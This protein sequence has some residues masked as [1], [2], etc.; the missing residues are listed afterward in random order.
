MKEKGQRGRRT[1]DPKS[2][3]NAR[4]RRN[5]TSRRA[6]KIRLLSIYQQTEAAIAKLRGAPTEES[7]RKIFESVQPHLTE[8]LA[9]MMASEKDAVAMKA[10]QCAQVFSMAVMESERA[11]LV[12]GAQVAGHVTNERIAKIQ[13]QME[14]KAAGLPVTTGPQL[15]EFTASDEVEHEQS[16]VAEDMAEA[17][18]DASANS[19]VDR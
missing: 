9:K 12:Y 1:G 8:R 5:R 6:R 11:R 7:F 17:V 14:L 15:H 16:T 18:A 13:A 19:A 4:G 10:I 2:L 3:K